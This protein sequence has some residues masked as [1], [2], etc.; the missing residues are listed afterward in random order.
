MDP[1]GFGLEN[2]NAIGA[3]R[4][5]DGSLPIDATGTLHG[6]T[7]NGESEMAQII[8]SDPEFSACL[9]N[10]L[11]TYALGRMPDLTSPNSMD[12]PALAT[13]TDQFKK[14]GL[15]FGQLLTS[16]VSSPSFLSRR[17]YP[18]GMP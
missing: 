18:G 8:A 4:T 11:F 10:K 5:M 12:A 15:Q 3:Y 17:G 16:I 6:Q 7:F 9:A 13:M 1:I 2:Y 14:G